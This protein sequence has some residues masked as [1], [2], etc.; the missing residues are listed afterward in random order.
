MRARSHHLNSDTSPCSGLFG[1]PCGYGIHN[2]D[3]I[4]DDDDDDNALYYIFFISK[5]RENQS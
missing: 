3:A 4:V 1:S 5:F 2:C